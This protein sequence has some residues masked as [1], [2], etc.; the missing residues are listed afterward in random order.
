M[1][2]GPLADLLCRSALFVPGA[3]QRK[4]ERAAQA[5]ADALI[6]DLEDAVAPTHK[7]LARRQVCEA[8]AGASAG[9]RLV[10]VN[11]LDTAWGADD[12]EAVAQAGAD[13]IVLPKCE[14]AAQLKAVVELLGSAPVTLIALIETPAGVLDLGALGDG[15]GRLLGLAF[16]HADF[17]RAAGLA[18]LRSD[19]GLAYHARCQVVLSARARGLAALDCVCLDVRDE[20]AF[21]ADAVL[22]RDLGYDGKLCIHPAQVAIANSIYTPA[23]EA[24]VRARSVV[25]A[26]AQAQRDGLGVIAVDGEM[27]DAPVAAVQARVLERARRAGLVG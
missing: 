12:V 13:G 8:L 6:F 4:L 14:Q 10:R 17:C 15:G 26:W 22:G 18:Q 5:A 7:D 27:V 21:R 3:D 16:G 20:E 2:L 19:I 23:P 1:L 11:G 24:V 9:L 25:D